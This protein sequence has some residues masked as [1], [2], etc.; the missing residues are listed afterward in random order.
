M[1][2]GFPI[3]GSSAI[4]WHTNLNRHCSDRIDGRFFLVALKKV[5]DVFWQPYHLSAYHSLARYAAR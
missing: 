5:L 3:K 4:L 1:G 2:Y